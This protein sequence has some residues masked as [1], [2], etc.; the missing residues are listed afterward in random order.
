M[1]SE[2]RSLTA[3]D[4]LLPSLTRGYDADHTGVSSQGATLWE[5]STL[6]LANGNFDVFRPALRSPSGLRVGTPGAFIPARG[7]RALEAD[8]NP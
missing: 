1:K 2:E 7:Y 4:H 5:G 3:A 6:D 8:P